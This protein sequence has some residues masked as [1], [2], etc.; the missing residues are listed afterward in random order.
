MPN[1]PRSKKEGII[2]G[3]FMVIIMSFCNIIINFGGVNAESMTAFG[4]SLPIMFVVAFLVENIIVSPIT[5]AIIGRVYKERSNT[6]VMVVLNAILIVP[7]MS[8]IMTFL[9]E[10]IGGT[11]I[12][13][14]VSTYL[15]VWPRNFCIAMFC[16]LLVA[17]PLA[18]LVLKGFQ[19]YFDKKRMTIVLKSNNTAGISTAP[20]AQPAYVQKRQDNVQKH[21]EE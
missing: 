19:K 13:E 16:N 12:G 10:L 18:R 7:L 11:P 15:T 1:L 4:I 6:S 2:F 20:Q 9:G 5:N 3:I 14:V 8:L 17:G 21:E